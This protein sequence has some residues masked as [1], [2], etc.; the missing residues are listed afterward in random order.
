MKGA[1]AEEL[2]VTMKH[3]WKGDSRYIYANRLRVSRER[4]LSSNTT[5]IS[6]QD[7]AAERHQEFVGNGQHDAQELL[8]I[9]LDA[10]HEVSQSNRTTDCIFSSVLGFESCAQ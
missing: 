9:V 2:G 5:M 8:T 10:I 4:R 6:I 7:F 3:L 1:M